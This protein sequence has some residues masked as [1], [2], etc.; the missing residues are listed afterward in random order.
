MPANHK[1]SGLRAQG[2]E[3]AIEHPYNLQRA[4]ERFERDYLCNILV[5]A[6]GDADYAAKMLGISPNALSRKIKKYEISSTLMTNS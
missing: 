2:T 6:G 3:N 1:Y 4:L 5:L